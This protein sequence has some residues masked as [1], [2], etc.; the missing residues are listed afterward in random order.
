MVNSIHFTTTKVDVYSGNEHLE[1][2]TG[3]FFRHNNNKYLVT[4]KHV[5]E[6]VRTRMFRENKKADNVR[7]ITHTDINDCSKHHTITIKVFDERKLWLEHPSIEEN[8]CDVVLIPLNENTLLGDNA[9]K[10]YPLSSPKITFVGQEL[11]NDF[12]LNEFGNLAVLGYPLGFYDKFNNLPISRRVTIASPYKVKFNNKPYFLVDGNLQPGMSGSPVF[13]TPHTLF[14]E[15]NRDEGSKLFG[16]YS[17]HKYAG[18]QPLNLHVIWYA[19]LLVE[20]AN[21][22]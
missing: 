21:Q 18:T 19:D 22:V 15:G 2:A 9:V 16:V 20:I 4:N 3:F 8:G 12:P 14:K 10:Y 5:V 13:C 11:V 6:C 1:R 7:I 17:A